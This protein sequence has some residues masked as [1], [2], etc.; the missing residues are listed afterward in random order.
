MCIFLDW[1]RLAGERGFV[2]G[3]TVTLQKACVGRDTSSCL[4]KNEIARNN[5]LYGQLRILPIA[6]NNGSR[7]VEGTESGDGFFWPGTR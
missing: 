5:I 3:Q 1:H 7:F 6:T 2:S 4:K